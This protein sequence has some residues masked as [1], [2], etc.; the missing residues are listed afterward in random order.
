MQTFEVV[1]EQGF[2]GKELIAAGD[3]QRFRA[4]FSGLLDRGVILTGASATVTSAVSTVTG[5]VLADDKKSL[6]WLINVTALGETFTLAFNVTTN[7]GQS[8]NY[9]VIYE[10]SAPVV[11]SNVPNPL[12]LIIGPSGPTGPAGTATNTGATGVTG[13]TGV[14][15][16]GS[17][18][19][20][21]PTGSTGST[22][23][24]SSVTGPTGFTGNTGPTGNTGNTGAASS[25]TGPTGFTGNTGSQGTAGA[26]STVTGPTGFTG[27]TGPA[28]AVTG[29]TGFTGVTG[30]T[31]A[32]GNTG[33]TGVTGPTGATDFTLN[34]QSAAYTT[35]LADDGRV[36]R[37]PSTDAN[38]RTF[39]IDSN[40]NVAYPIGAAITFVNETS[41]AV[42]IAI[43]SDTMTLANS[44]STGSR[45]LAQN[46]IAT[47]IK[48]TSTTWII[49]GAGIS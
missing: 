1:T 6:Y 35:V 21:G 2:L 10:T 41:Q 33:A 18:G 44:T 5:V 48:L 11:S 7:D 20:T 23:A 17:T 36:I 19:L 46:G 38:A 40:A 31:G 22:G 47:A 43:T 8:L 30:P 12:P 42:T 9:T 28:S 14:T 25:V 3:V 34:N 37:H 15:G 24:S 32:T 39:T 4:N 27:N 16:F 13:P 45:T 29:P 49:S 26:A